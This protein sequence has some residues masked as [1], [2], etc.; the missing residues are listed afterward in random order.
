LPAEIDKEA[1]LYP[2]WLFC[3][4]RTLKNPPAIIPAAALRKNP[5]F[6]YIQT[7]RVA[8]A[9]A[10]SALIHAVILWL[11]QIQL[12]HAKVELPPLTARIEHLPEIQKAPAEKPTQANLASDTGT[13][14]KPASATVPELDKMPAMKATAEPAAP[15]Q[16]PKHLRLTFSFYQNGDSFAS[17][18]M[19]QKLDISSGRYILKAT[20]RTDGLAR[21]RNRVELIQTSRG[22]IVAQ[23]LR[24]ETFI[25]EEFGEDGKQSENAEFGW[26][27]H[28]LR[29]SS[30]SDTELPADAQDMLSFMY[31]LSQIPLNVEFFPLAISDGSK[32]EAGQIEVGL[33]EQISTPM[34]KLRVVHLRKMHKPR[35]AYFEIWL[36][37]EYRLLP[38][39]ISRIDSSGNVTEE[40]VI[41]DIRATEE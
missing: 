15:L 11:P 39:K 13:N 33:K 41:S 24:P 4:S 10:L 40:F 35:E 1:G 30:G 9:I 31:Q 3:G 19:R 20:L 21:W 29:L 6:T 25:Q 32:L 37:L 18:E 8:I 14:G 12:P 23:G 36:G 16:F 28:K 17:G 2:A 5:L 34:G 26:A 22:S 27:E 38:V 7:H